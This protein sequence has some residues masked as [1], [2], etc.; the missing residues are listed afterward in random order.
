[1]PARG[2]KANQA[3]S[4]RGKYS[5]CFDDTSIV[6]MHGSVEADV[7]K[8]DLN[9]ACRLGC[10]SEGMYTLPCGR[11]REER[12][13]ASLYIVSTETCAESCKFLLFKTYVNLGREKELL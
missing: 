7:K 8:R 13:G 5:I 6:N 1:M 2:I 12:L 10:E 4:L 3:K 9:R 11:Y